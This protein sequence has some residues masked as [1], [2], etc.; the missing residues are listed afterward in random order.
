ME[1]YLPRFFKGA[2]K[3]YRLL[4]IKTASINDE[5]KF[6]VPEKWQLILR[7]NVLIGLDLEVFN[8]ICQRFY[9]QLNQLSKT[10]K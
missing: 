9:A 10:S 5:S 4:K 1:A 7:K 6:T 2:L 8:F 3:A